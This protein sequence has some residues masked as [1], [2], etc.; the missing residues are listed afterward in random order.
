M[1]DL[2]ATSTKEISNGLR[3][4][5]EHG[6]AL[7]DRRAEGRELARRLQRLCAD[8]RQG[9]VGR[10]RQ[11]DLEGGQSLPSADLPAEGRRSGTEAEAGRRDFVRTPHQVFGARAWARAYLWH[12][13]EFD[14]HE[15]VDALAVSALETDEAQ[16]ILSRAFGAV[17]P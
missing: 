5:T 15:A 7:Q 16:A 17:R 13:G 1:P 10:P 3:N 6:L 11:E 14:L 4:E 8:G 9:V 12:A 2:R